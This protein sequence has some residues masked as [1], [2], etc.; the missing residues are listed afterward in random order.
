MH[1]SWTINKILR[2]IRYNILQRKFH[3]VTAPLRT[4]PDFLVIGAK[5]CGTTSLYH[6]LGLHPSIKRSTHDHLGFFDDN[7][8][9]GL[10][11]Y[12][13]FFPTVVEKRACLKKT[14]MFATYDVTSSYIQDPKTAKRIHDIFPQIKL[15]AI[16][17]N[18]ADRAYS[19]YNLQLRSDPSMKDFEFY[20]KNEMV[21]IENDE[22]SGLVIDAKLFA[23]GKKNYLRKGF[24]FEQFT[25]WFGLFPKDN[26]HII[27]TEQLGRNPDETMKDIFK[28][29]GFP[30]HQINTE[31]RHEKGN[32]KIMNDDTRESLQ[33]F[34]EPRNKKLYEL[35][36][37]NF[38][39]NK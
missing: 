38:V 37:K 3:G 7:F 30:D 11:F 29:L 9:L 2:V 35:I 19:E 27:S 22:K 18:P 16:L 15:I 31:K 28:F 32:Y 14:G 12:R 34:F 6:Y 36:G 26:I 39:W 20:V 33:K 1:K 8:H 4:L 21:E 10:Q 24:Y 23:A 25:P 5:R 17:R 13:S